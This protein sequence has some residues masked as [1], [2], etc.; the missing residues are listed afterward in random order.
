MG[1]SRTRADP[2]AARNAA[3]RPKL[4]R[5]PSFFDFSDPIGSGKLSVTSTIPFSKRYLKY[6]TK[7]FLKRNQSVPAALVSSRFPVF[8]S[9]C[10]RLVPFCTLQD[11]RV[12]PRCCYWSV[13]P[14]LTVLWPLPESL[15][16]PGSC[17]RLL[18][19]R[20]STRSSSSTSRSRVRARPTSK[21]RL[22]RDGGI[23]TRSATSLWVVLL[24]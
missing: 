21:Q 3:A 6:L 10:S 14:P 17:C 19:A 7:R 4:V 23:L 24:L 5:L 16:T 22:F 2:S 11:A 9:F 1:L 18:Q 15:L 20:T 12:A 13:Y 8:R